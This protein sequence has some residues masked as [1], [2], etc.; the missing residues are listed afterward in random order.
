MQ[1]SKWVDMGAEVK[2]DIGIDDIRGA[3]QEAFAKV[4]DDRLGESGPNLS[5]V[6]MALNNIGAFLNAMTD[7]QIGLLNSKQREIIA[8]F[9]LEQG[10]RF[11]FTGTPSVQT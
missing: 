4:T 9:L 5:E 8:T 10:K 7:E 11:Q 3:M 6:F 2:V 1:I